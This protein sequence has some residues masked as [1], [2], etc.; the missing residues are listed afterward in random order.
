MT[1][2]P[3]C[4]ALNLVSFPVLQGDV[5]AETQPR[6]GLL[7]SRKKALVWLFTYHDMIQ[8]WFYLERLLSNFLK[9]ITLATLYFRTNPRGNYIF[10]GRFFKMLFHI[11]NF[12]AKHFFFFFFPSLAFHYLPNFSCFIRVG[13]RYFSQGKPVSLKKL[14]KPLRETQANSRV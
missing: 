9:D 2:Y 13:L 11:S 1:L 10:F 4:T 14:M 7:L 8:L 6:R 12:T 3:Q 5:L